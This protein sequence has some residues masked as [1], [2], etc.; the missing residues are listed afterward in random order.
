M[1]SHAK[2]GH[3]ALARANRVFCT[4]KK[5]IRTENTVTTK[6]NNGLGLSLYEIADCARMAFSSVRNRRSA[7]TAS[8]PRKIA[9]LQHCA[10]APALAWQPESARRA[11][12]AGLG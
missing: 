4:D 12:A 2:S 6:S 5:R 9:T 11:Q 10:P 8:R 1:L 7:R 3:C